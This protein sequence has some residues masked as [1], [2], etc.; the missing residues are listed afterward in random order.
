MAIHELQRIQYPAYMIL[1]AEFG[2]PHCPGR[3]TSYRAMA[4]ARSSSSAMSAFICK[5]R[6][7]R[8]IAA[9]VT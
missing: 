3:S 1:H 5:R 8:H 9:S 7:E 2:E 6:A 4:A